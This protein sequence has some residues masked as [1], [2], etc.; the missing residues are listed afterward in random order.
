M[1]SALRLLVGDCQDTAAGYC[2]QVLLNIPTIAALP[3]G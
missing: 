3:S 2:P 1:T